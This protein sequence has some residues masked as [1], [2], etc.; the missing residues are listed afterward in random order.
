MDFFVQFTFIDNPVSIQFQ[1]PVNRQLYCRAQATS[2]S[3]G[4]AIM[5]SAFCFTS[6]F[7]STSSAAAAASII[8]TA[9]DSATATAI[10]Q[11]PHAKLEAPR[12]AAGG[13]GGGR[14]GQMAEIHKI[15]VCDLGW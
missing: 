4:A 10:D 8:T 13:G 3:A 6:A 15:R 2:T 14:R 9:C 1:A 5:T 12:G 7:T 11:L